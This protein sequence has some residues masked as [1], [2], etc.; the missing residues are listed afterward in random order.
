MDSAFFFHILI[1]FGALQG[2]FLSIVIFI[3]KR[4]LSGILLAIF[5]AIEGY[6][7]I[8][9]LLAETNLMVEFPHIIGTSHA[10]SFLKPPILFLLAL[11]IVKPTFKL[12]GIHYLHGIPFAASFIF[13][14]PFLMLPGSAKVESA[15]NF[16]KSIPGYDTPDF[17]IF[18]LYF[19][20]MGVYFYLSIKALREY[21]SH[22][23][24]NR[25]AN[26]FYKVLY[27]Y[28]G[29]MIIFLVHFSLRPIGLFDLPINEYS[30]V[31]MTFLNSINCVW[32]SL[33]IQ[34]NGC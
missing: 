9:R 27:L 5:L 30:M 29:L 15:A 16:L 7:L 18:F 3:G 11:S 23:K 2:I 13:S 10:I 8:E 32:F 19:L 17:W 6:S 25:L 28:I 21:K 4:S 12:R 20:Y 33:R 31:L 34:V 14:I 1:V 22:V 24:N 26:W